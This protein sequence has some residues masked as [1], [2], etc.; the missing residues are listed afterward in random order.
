MFFWQGQWMV[1]FQVATEHLENAFVRA[2]VT[3]EAGMTTPGT[4]GEGDGRYNAW[5]TC[6]SVLPTTVLVY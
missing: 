5:L 3:N 4:V 1:F 2:A 6:I